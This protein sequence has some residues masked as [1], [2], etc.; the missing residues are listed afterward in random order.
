MLVGVVLALL[1]GLALPA[2]PRFAARV[3]VGAAGLALLMPVIWNSHRLEAFEVRILTPGLAT[4]L[5]TFSLPADARLLGALDGRRTVELRR[6][7]GASALG[8]LWIFSPA[9]STVV[10]GLAVGPAPDGGAR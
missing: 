1:L 9:R 7:A 2:V 8:S 5:D 6:P 4:D 3:L 10:D